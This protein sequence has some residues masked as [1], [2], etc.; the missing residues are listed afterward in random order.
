MADGHIPQGFWTNTLASCSFVSTHCLDFPVSAKIHLMVTLMTLPHLNN[1]GQQLL[2]CITITQYLI[3]ELAW[4]SWT[5]KHKISHQCQN[6]IIMA[7]LESQNSN[8]TL[9]A[10][11]LDIVSVQIN[12]LCLFQYIYCHDMHQFQSFTSWSLVSFL[13]LFFFKLH[14]F[15]VYQPFTL[16]RVI[17][18]CRA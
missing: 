10:Y 13:I 8:K 1:R 3:T 12:E 18:S 5:H 11:I 17:G 6:T 7:L 9:K 15:S 2:K 4:A 16:F 14:L